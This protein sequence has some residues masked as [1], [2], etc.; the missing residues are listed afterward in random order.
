MSDAATDRSPVSRDQRNLQRVLEH[1]GITV[2]LDVGANIG[3][4]ARRLRQ[5]GYSGRIVSFEPLSA[6]HTALSRAAADDPLWTVAPRLA[7]GDSDRPVRLNISAESD[8][9]SVLDF[10]REMADLLDSSAYVGSEVASQARLEAVFAKH[11]GPDDRVLLK[12]DTQGYER[13]V[14]EG[15]RGVLKRIALVQLELS[16]VPVY[17]DETPWLEMVRLLEGL[18]YEPVLFLPGYFNR[19]TAR[20]ISMDGVFA[21][22]ELI[23]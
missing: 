14:I 7:L 11:A 5:G 16:I 3:Q 1:H 8:M 15:A 23:A 19:R 6:A 22:N 4:Y 2:V 21:R 9:S 20:L 12:I 17:R 13:R 10:T 18:G